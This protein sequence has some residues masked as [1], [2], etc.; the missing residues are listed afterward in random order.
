MAGTVVDLNPSE[1]GAL[2]AGDRRVSVRL[3]TGVVIRFNTPLRYPG[4]RGNIVV[5]LTPAEAAPGA[6]RPVRISD[7]G[8]LIRSLDEQGLDLET[9]LVLSKTVFHAIKEVEGAGLGSGEIYLD[10]T[11]ESVPEDVWRFLQLVTE[12][13][14]L[15]HAKYKDALLQL[16]K[17][18]EQS[19]PRLAGWD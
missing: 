9:D 10:S 15:R 19:V 6:E 2:L 1:A 18:Q 12:L 8:G 14:G 7:G 11:A 17:R 4:R 13:L 3:A 5:V 16:S